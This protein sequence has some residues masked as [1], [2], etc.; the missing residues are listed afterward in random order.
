MAP[1]MDRGCK[2]EAYL[3]KILT[4]EWAPIPVVDTTL[5]HQSAAVEMNV[6]VASPSPEIPVRPN[7]TR[8]NTVAKPEAQRAK[9]A[10][11]VFVTVAIAL[12]LL[13]ACTGSPSSGAEVF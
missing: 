4:G 13:K 9:W 11:F 5:Y 2:Y 8:G 6:P 1:V 12:I 3:T 10:P 7:A